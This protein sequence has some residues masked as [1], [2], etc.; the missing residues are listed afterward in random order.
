MVEFSS[1]LIKMAILG[2]KMKNEEWS[3]DSISQPYKDFFDT[4]LPDINKLINN[5]P[6][7]GPWYHNQIW[8]I[9]VSTEAEL[10]VWLGL[11]KGK[12]K[13]SDSQSIFME[14]GPILKESDK[15]I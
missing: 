11:M 2:F 8:G 4:Y 7:S 12:K 14:Q 6:W 10:D 13:E 5:D 1:Y 9:E 3:F 15:N